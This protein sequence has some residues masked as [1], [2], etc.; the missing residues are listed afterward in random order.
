MPELSIQ[1]QRLRAM[2]Q[3]CGYTLEAAAERLSTTK[4][5]IYKYEMGIVQNIPADK[6]LCLA[7]LYGCSADYLKG[8][9][10]QPGQPPEGTAA[11][12]PSR[13][14]SQRTAQELA[15]LC[16]RLSPEERRTVIEFARFLAS[17]HEEG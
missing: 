4:Q 17:R 9:T 11:P 12:A 13:T 14:T 10:D 15:D 6:L 3:Q 1:G 16:A 2:R 8:L 5:A 7:Q